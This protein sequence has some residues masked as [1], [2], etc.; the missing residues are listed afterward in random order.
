[1]HNQDPD[2]LCL[3]T[4]LGKTTADWLF[5]AHHDGPT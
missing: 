4:K 1:L 3:Q 2:L 5:T